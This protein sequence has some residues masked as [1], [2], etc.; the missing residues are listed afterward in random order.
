MLVA[1]LLVR[2]RVLEVEP[3]AVLLQLLLAWRLVVMLFSIHVSS[4]SSIPVSIRRSSH[5]SSVKAL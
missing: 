4:Y 5:V 2:V 3:S 1:V